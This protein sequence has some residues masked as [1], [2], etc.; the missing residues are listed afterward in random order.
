MS[1]HPVLV[2]VATAVT[3]AGCSL[4]GEREAGSARS[5]GGV[6]SAPAQSASNRDLGSPEAVLYTKGV[7]TDP[8]GTS[9]ADGFG[10][11]TD[12][13]TKRQRTIEARSRE[14]GWFGGAGWIDD[15][16]ILVARKAPPFRRPFIYRFDGRTLRRL[17]PAPVPALEPG[18]VWSP[19][20]SR[21]ASEPIEPCA[22]SQRT[23]WQCYRSSGRVLVRDGDGSHVRQVAIGSFNSWTPDGRLLV[24][25]RSGSRPY[26]ALDV[27]TGARTIPLSPA[28]VASRFRLKKVSVAAPRWSA[29]RRFM[30]AMVGTSWP[31]RTKITAA[32]VLARADGRPIRLIRS[33]YIISMF[34]WSPIGHRL[35][36]TTSGFP[37]PHQLFVV[38]TPTAKPKPLFVTA[39]HFDWVTWSPD[40]RRLLVDDEH[41]NRWWLLSTV[42]RHTSRALPRLGGRP[43]W[44][45][46]LNAFGTLNG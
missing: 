32:L 30:A 11:V 20:G 44:C 37:T 45:C 34:A 2:A 12:I 38:D 33:P 16:R 31:K 22:K 18:P 25:D 4:V 40:A 27:R 6:G 1:K 7:S 36:Y 13:G 43:L 3:L 5:E 46:P 24:T 39:R 41:K 26:A 15:H 29:D 35:A 19:D 9:A 28:P 10:V 23:I 14:L 17:G 42:G 21:I 8:Y